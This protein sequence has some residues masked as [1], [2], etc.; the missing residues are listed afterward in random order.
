MAAEQFD[1]ASRLR[2]RAI[3]SRCSWGSQH[4][5][6]RRLQ[7]PLYS[8]S[9][10]YE[11]TVEPQ[12]AATTHNVIYELLAGLHYIQRRTAR[13]SGCGPGSWMDS[14]KPNSMK[15]DVHSRLSVERIQTEAGRQVLHMG[16]VH[17]GATNRGDSMSNPQTQRQDLNSGQSRAST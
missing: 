9:L 14:N 8:G 7:L 3:Q 1:N 4:G 11:M 16:I 5:R 17:E 15:D 12:V 2:L 6:L 10:L 13:F